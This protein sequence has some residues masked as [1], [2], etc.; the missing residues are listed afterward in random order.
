MCAKVFESE[1]LSDVGKLQIGKCGWN[2]IYW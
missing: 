1:S 2:K